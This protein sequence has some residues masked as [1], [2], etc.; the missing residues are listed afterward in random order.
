VVEW[1][2]VEGAVVMQAHSADEYRG[3]PQAK[4]WPV[5][6]MARLFLDYAGNWARVRTARIPWGDSSSEF[7][8]E[9]P[10]HPTIHP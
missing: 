4:P 1:Q 5:T 10:Y 6:R 3:A 8:T 7:A 2:D 9:R